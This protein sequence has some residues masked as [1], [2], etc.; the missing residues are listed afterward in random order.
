MKICSWYYR[1][2]PGA[3]FSA[4]LLMGYS[5]LFSQEYESIDSATYEFVNYRY[6]SGEEE[7]SGPKVPD[8]L[9]DFSA[10]SVSLYNEF[11]SFSSRTNGLKVSAGSE[12][13]NFH[14]AYLYRNYSGYLA[15]SSEYWN[16]VDVGLK[17]TPSAH[18][19]LTILGTYLNGRVNLPGSLTKTEF[20]Q[21]PYRADQRAIDRDEKNIPVTGTLNIKYEA[22]FGKSLNNKVEILV[23][24]DINNYQSATREYRIVS[25]YGIGL[26][27]TYSNSSGFWKRSNTVTA[28]IQLEVQ[29]QRTEYYD[30]MGGQKGDLIE[31]LTSERTSKAGAF[32]TDRFE[33]LRKKLFILL[34]GRFDQEVY[35]LTEETLPSRSDRR[36]FTAFTPKV[37]LDYVPVS[38]LVLYASLHSGFKSPADIELESPDPFYLYN[39][40]LKPQ[41]SIDYE[42]G[43]KINLAKEDSSGMF[44]GFHA[45][46]SFFQ[47]FIDNEIVPYEVFGDIFFRNA[48]KSNRYGVEIE[49]RLEIIRGLSFDL[50]YIYSHFRYITYQAISIEADTTGNIIQI[51]RDYS[52]NISPGIPEHF[53]GLSLSYRYPIGK[54]VELDG[55]SQ[56]FGRY[57]TLGG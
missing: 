34:S 53:L 32:V 19:S 4:L 28:G 18:T 8:G 5:T 45:K 21:D 30:N 46:G 13:Y 55:Q 17:T 3:L 1:S 12:H 44:P 40:T 11:G 15:H 22:E 49:S 54:K 38:W 7:T 39:P 43:I 31:Q 48:A 9:K 23:R 2:L 6:N 51:D 10:S 29:P 47:D 41:Y 57:R 50:S 42:G 26:D 56:L 27:A 35:E 52:G 16:I 14:T 24:S 37:T 25:R 20:E 33:I 36:T